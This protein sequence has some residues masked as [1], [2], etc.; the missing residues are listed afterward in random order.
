M[1]GAKHTKVEVLAPLLS[2]DSSVR[3]K[4]LIGQG[5]RLYCSNDWQRLVHII[6]KLASDQ[7][8]QICVSLVTASDQLRQ[9]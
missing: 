1:I 9:N 8:R 4:V 2:K 5:R 7:L 6:V 3:L